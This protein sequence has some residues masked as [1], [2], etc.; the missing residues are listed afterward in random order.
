MEDESNPWEPVPPV[1]IQFDASLPATDLN[2]ELRDLDDM[3]PW[4]DPWQKQQSQEPSPLGNFGWAESTSTLEPDVDLGNSFPEGVFM[5][6]HAATGK[7]LDVPRSSKK[8]WYFIY[9]LRWDNKPLFLE[10]RRYYSMGKEKG[11]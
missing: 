4:A 6:K 7:V 2:A 9:P 8:V 10:G 11:R 3:D 5:I 1:K